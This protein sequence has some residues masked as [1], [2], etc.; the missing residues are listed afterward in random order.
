M[1][2]FSAVAG[3]IVGALLVLSVLA[4]PHAST[5]SKFPGA[6]LD[7]LGGPQPIS[8][9]FFG[10]GIRGDVHIGATSATL[11][12][13]T[14]VQYLRYPD[15][16]IGER[17]D[18][19]NGT[20]YDP[21]FSNTSA[22]PDNLS[23]FIGLCRS[24]DCHAIIQLPLEIDSPATAAYEVA[25]ITGA[26][27]FS[28]AYW[29]LGNEPAAW[30]CF[31][32][33]WQDWGS[34]CSGGTTPEQFAQVTASYIA[35]VRAVEPS[36]QFVGLGGTGQ[37]NSDDATW[38]TPLETID[39][40]NLSA[41]SIHSYVDNH[42]PD[43]QNT[44]VT[45]FF[46]GLQA[47]YS[48]PNIVDVARSA[49]HAAC[50]NCT[51]QIFVTELNS[52]SGTEPLSIYLNTFYNGLFY[53]AE[54]TQAVNLGLGNLDPFTWENGFITSTGPQA[55]YTVESQVLPGLLGESYNVSVANPGVYA[56]LTTDASGQLSLMI[57]DTNSTSGVS[58]SF[59]NATLGFGDG[60][61]VLTWTN[62]SASPVTSTLAGGPIAVPSLSIVLVSGT[63]QEN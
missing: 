7:I 36:A 54:V 47:E 11:L 31:G 13:A 33:P 41:I 23:D 27:G 40:A 6:E 61:H 34:G 4:P 52:V 3:V 19:V 22:A 12:A 16:D 58:L 8:P 15:G 59:G 63:S 10:M 46:S 20:L 39:G 45:N 51:T 53:A 57:V 42:I 56:A 48:L 28:P 1:L 25:Y 37:G 60:A 62:S 55:R 32:T 17:M 2:A 24:I 29:E 9:A 18:L 35:A 26:L 30:T 49:V 43:P 21:G 14:P 5:G 38:I 50:P 44:T